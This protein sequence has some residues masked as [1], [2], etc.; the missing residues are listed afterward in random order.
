[1]YKRILS[2]CLSV[3]LAISLF[4]YASLA[5]PEA[6]KIY[7]D[8]NASN[9]PVAPTLTVAWLSQQY[10][11]TE[12]WISAELNA[13]YTLFELKQALDLEKSGLTYAAAMEQINPAVKKQQEELARLLHETL[14]YQTSVTDETYA[15]VLA[16]TY[17][18]QS[19]QRPLDLWSV[20]QS[21]YSP[22]VTDSTY[23]MMAASAAERPSTYDAAVLSR[24][25]SRTS[26]APYSVSSLN[27]TV[28]TLSGDLSL[29][30]QDLSL[31]GRNGLSFSLGR[32]YDSSDAYIYE[33]NVEP[34]PIYTMAFLPKYF[35]SVY[36]GPYGTSKAP[37]GEGY[38]I[39]RFDYNYFGN[40]ITRELGKKYSTDP[41]DQ[42]WN[43]MFYYTYAQ[44]ALDVEQ[45]KLETQYFPYQDPETASPAK[46]YRFNITTYQTGGTVPFI[47]KFYTTGNVTLVDARYDGSTVRNA[48]KQDTVSPL[49]K[50]WSWD[51]PE[52]ISQYNEKYLKL[53]GGGRYKIGADNTLV[54]YPWKD[55]TLSNDLSV[56]VNGKSST[57]VL[58]SL[59]GIKHYF[60]YDGKLIRKSDAYGNNID[61]HYTNVSPYGTV[62]TKV[63]DALGNEISL[64]YSATEVV[65]TAGERTIRY[66]KQAAANTNQE[67]LTAV[68]DELNRTTR[69]TYNVAAGSFNLLPN[70]YEPENN[71]YALV[72]GVEH[73]TG[74]R[75]EY[76]YSKASRTI[77]K[78]SESEEYYRVQSREDVVYYANGTQER[79]NKLTFNGGDGSYGSTTTFQTQTNNGRSETTYSYKKQYIDEQT[80]PVYYLLSVKEQAEGITR[81]QQSTYDETKR[82]PTPLRTTTQTTS[83][84]GSSPEVT[85]QRTYDEYGNVLTET[86]PLHGDVQTT[87]TYDPTTHLLRSMRTPLSASQASVMEL[88]RNGQKSV[89]QQTVKEEATGALQ[90]QTNYGYDGYGN[91][92]SMTIRD[93]QRN[94]VVS[95][96]FGGTYNGGFPTAQHVNVTDADGYTSTL[97]LRAAYNRNTGRMTQFTDGKGFITSYQYDA[98]GRVTKEILPDASETTI[99]YDDLQNKVTIKDPMGRQTVEEYNALGEK[100]KETKGLSQVEVKYD[101]FGRLQWSQDILGHRTENQY[102][103]WNRI[104]KVT[105]PDGSQTN[106]DYDD[107]HLTKTTT[108]AESLAIRETYDAMGRVTTKEEKKGTGFVVVGSS[109]YDYAGSPTHQT[110]G[111]GHVT[112]YAY[113]S[114]SRLTSVTDPEE[115]TTQYS[116]SLAGQMTT[117]HYPDGNTLQ[118][119]Y[120]EIGRPIKRIDAGGQVDSTYYDANGN[121]AKR[122]DR[123]G[124]AMTYTYTNRNF[125]L[126][127]TAA[128]ESISYT[129]N[130]NGQR[131]SMK[132]G[133]GTTAYGYD[134]IQG[135]LT[136]V[137]FPD[138]RHIQYQYDVMG[139]RTQMTDPFGYQTVY[140][141][142]ARDR[143]SGVGETASKWEESYTYKRNGLLDTT[144]QANG[145]LWRH[146]YEGWNRTGLTQSKSNGTMVNAFGYTYDNNRNQTSKTENGTSYAF[147][148]DK[149]DRISTS[150]QLSEAYTYDARGNRLTLQSDRMLNLTA[151]NYAYDN[152]NRLTTVQLENGTQVAYRYN[153]DGLLYERTEQGTTIRYYYDGVNMIAEGTVTPT[154]VNFKARYVRGQGLAYRMDAGGN[155]HY[156][157]QNG[158]G[159]IVGL[160]DSAGNV[161]NRYSYDI[162]GNPL[163][164]SEQ[165]EQP[166]RYSG[167]YWDASTGL[168]YLRAR[169][170]DPSVGRFMNEDTYEGDITNPLTLNLYTYVGNNPL[171]Y[172]DPTGN[173]WT[174][175]ETWR[176]TK[177]VG[178]DVWYVVKTGSSNI[179]DEAV[180]A[181]DELVDIHSSW[182]TAVDYWSMG[183]VTE[184]R[185]YIKISQEKPMSI[186]QWT[187]AGFLFFEYSP[188]GKGSS[189][190][191]NGLIDSQVVR[192]TQDSISRV[193][194]NG[195]DIY[196][197]I[198]DLKKGVVK[199]EDIPEIRIFEYKNNFYTLDNRRLF[200][201]QEAG[202]QI[203]YRLATQEEVTNEAWKFT[204]KNDG[205]SIRVRGGSN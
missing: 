154:G 164:E 86:H 195:T 202:M 180:G 117:L 125:M 43:L 96:E 36:F 176:K 79:K 118:Y 169:W 69:Y 174:M 29:R 94:T 44:G 170:Y 122:I 99:V 191:A 14:D 138:G 158:H 24:L 162:W 39:N 30:N 68:T 70:Y 66:T 153:G 54:G 159:D 48:V 197:T 135:T 34:V 16:N 185:D 129:Y 115:R 128:D 85:I 87:Y 199:I 182:D 61:F 144:T 27:E 156:Y 2:A 186:E 102:D 71:F 163:T 177:N 149:L 77:G 90:Q 201:A 8:T 107:I 82:W 59:E 58:T 183:A 62:L 110:D 64:S 178:N 142:D 146:G 187:A 88:E 132:D 200:A 76:Q 93:D 22:T 188:Q 172:I 148:Y 98:G 161:V 116:Y 56:T 151:G 81:T 130:R 167:E 51:V 32:Q 63:M 166:F 171:K 108:D 41:W 72:T 194:K 89:T 175:A 179:K 92:T 73:P 181:W 47:A 25:G 74:A 141:Y 55:I 6:F 205:T 150:S 137:T 65:A 19:Q 114:L 131:E 173:M 46:S 143:L 139:K 84:A 100:W 193:F 40:T 136:Q 140:G 23:R 160:A 80:P 13:G 78:A 155:K 28:S 133:T 83:S 145:M 126:S 109:Q 192:F 50:G 21:T 124:Q 57:Q 152:R 184:I 111:N 127:S 101:S 91:M 134:P 20:T 95:Q 112:R 35:Y 105:H 106:V 123:K 196:D 103:K 119:R 198:K 165:V 157:L 3:I 18:D 190:A 104:T 11:K 52:I 31:P 15:T 60:S 97:T 67:L 189:I 9:Q 204:T 33:K 147:S 5:Q 53:P 37:G 113:D 10:G 168:Q 4:P 1:M 203:K 120:D 38:M 42:P 75:T 45:R 7:L 12:S 26:Q 17:K 121:V 49:G